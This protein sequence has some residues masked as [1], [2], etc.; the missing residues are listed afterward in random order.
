MSFCVYDFFLVVGIMD[1]PRG[2]RWAWLLGM[3]GF[4]V[5]VLLIGAVAIF[6]FTFTEI[7]PFDRQAD[8]Q[9][10]PFTMLPPALGCAYLFA[11]AGF[12]SYAPKHGVNLIRSLLIISATMVIPLAAMQPHSKMDSNIIAWISLVLVTSITCGIFVIFGERKIGS[13]KTDTDKTNG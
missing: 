8:M 11:L 9:R 7:H 2:I 1:I 5:P 10:L 13:N 12:A 6:V 3:I 4:L